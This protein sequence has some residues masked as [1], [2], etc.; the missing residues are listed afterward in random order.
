MKNSR[1]GP[2][3]SPAT[4]GGVADARDESRPGG[5]F[6]IVGIG[7]SAGGLEAFSAL[8]KHL[9]LDTGMGF[10]LVQHLDP[11]H[12]SALTQLLG[13]ASLLPVHEVTNNLRVEPNHV[14]VIPPNTNLGITAGVLTLRPR[15]RTRTPHRSIDF[16]LEAL[17]KDQR[18]H[19]IGV[20]LSGTATDGTL[21]LEAIKAEG[22]ITFAQDDSARYDSMPRSAVAAGAVDFILSPEDVARELARIAKHPAVAGGFPGGPASAGDDRASATANEDDRGPQEAIAPRTEDGF[23]KILLLLRNHSS[24]DFSLYKSSTIQRRITRRMVLTKHDTRERYAQFLRGNSKELGAL[25]SDVLISVTSFFRNP[26]AFEVLRRKVWPALLQQRGDEPLRVWTVGCS[27]GQEAYSLAMSFVEA[28][29]KAPRM[30][31]LQLFATDLNDALLDKARQGLYAKNVAQDLSSERLRRFFV[32]EAS[33]YR[34]SK[35][36]REMVV[37]ARQNVVSDPPFSRMDLISCRN[38]LI[39]FEPGLQRK[40]FPA[41]HYALKPGA[42][43]YLGASESVGGFTELFDPLDKKHRIYARKAAPTPAFPLQA[44]KGPGEPSHL[45]RPIREPRQRQADQGEVAEGFRGELSARREADRVSANRFAPPAVL[46]NADLQILQF[47]GPTGAYLE[48]PTG[49]PSFDVLKM[50]RPG[51]ML[52]LRSAINKAKK[53]NTR[54]RREHVRLEGAGKARMVNVE[55]IPLR[56]LRERCFLVV[57]EDADKAGPAPAASRGTPRLVEPPP[58]RADRAPRA[59]ESRR[60]TLLEAELAETRGYVQSIQEPHAAANEELQAS[61]QEVQSANEELQSIN[62]ELETFKE[63]LE[64]A[65]EELTTLNDE[66]ADRHTEL[67]RLHSDLVN[68]QTSAHL[69]IVLLGRDLTI[70]RFSAHAAKQLNLLASDVGRPLSHVRHTLEVSDLEPFVTEVID[71]VRAREREVQ[72]R[73]GRWLSL[74]VRPYLTLDNK[75]DGAVLVLVD[76]DDLKR[77][78]LAL[79]AAR[80]YA[81]S[82]IGTIRDPLVVL[83][84]DLRVESV[85]RAFYRTFGVTPADTIGKFIYELGNRQW[86]I[87][88]FRAL[89]EE[90]LPE[91]HTI[92]DFL[93]EWD[94]EPRGRRTMLLNAR[95]MHSP[96]GIPSRIVVAIDDIT[97]RKQTEEKL[98]GSEQRF[99]RF[100]EHLPGL[101]WI[102]DAHGRYVYANDAAEKAFRR[103]RTQLY[104]KSDRDLFPQETAARFAAND[105]QVQDTESSIQAIE[106]LEHEDGIVHQSIVSKFSIPGSDGEAGLVG[107]VAIDIT[108]LKEA[109][110]AL[111]KSEERYRTLFASIDEGFCVIERVEGPPSAPLDFRYVE[112]NPAFAAHTGV[113]GVVG[114][115]IRQAFPGEPEAW[116]HTYDHVL[117]TG[118]AMRFECGLVTQGRVLELYA[119]RIEDDSHRRVAVIFKDVTAR[120]RAEEAQARLAAI[121]ASSDDA[122]VSKDLDGVITSWNRG[123]ERLFGYSAQE[124]IGQPI[125]LLIPPDRLD[126]ERGIVERI[127]RGEGVDHFETIRRRRDGT[128]FDASVTV[129]PIRDSGGT[130]V[131]ASKIA[132]DIT[133]RNRAEAAVRD[134]EE[135][136]RNLFDLGPVAVYSCDAAGVIQTFNRRA[137]ELWGREPVPGDTDQRFCGSFKMFRPDGRFMPHEQCPMAEVLAGIISEARDAEV[138]IERPDGTRVI[139]VVNIR[140]LKNQHGEITGAI[141]CFYDITERKQ[142][143]EAMRESDR[144]KSEFL[145]MLAHELRNPLAPILGSIEVLSRARSVE[146]PHPPS[147]QGR[148]DESGATTPD[149][150][151]RIDHA[152]DV[153]QRQVGHM[154]R[155]VDDLLDAG[156]ISR[157]KID[158][159]RERVE[160]SSVLHHVV[161]AVRPSSE[162][163]DQELTVTLPSVPVYLDADSTRLAQIVG[164]LLNNA[165]KFTERGGHIWLTAERGE[166]SGA[167]HAE[168]ASARSAPHVVIRVRDTGI[169]IAAEPLEHVFDMF[170]QGD[171][172]LER[173]L[174]GLGIGLTLVKTLTEMH[175]GTVE[176]RSGGVGQG[177]E[178][179]VRLPIAVET[180]TP[181]SPP[182]ATESVAPT[183]LRILIVDDNR[184]SADMLDLLLKRAGHETHTAHDGLAA[185]EAA[186]SLDPDVILLDIGL[187]VLN[188]YEAARRIREQQ[189]QK[190]RPLLVALT[191]WGQDEDRRRSREAGFDAHVVKPVNDTVLNR[192]LAELDAG[193]QEVRD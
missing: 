190:R 124:A 35:A 90:I 120:R 67:N 76:I 143:E 14:Y 44:R 114:K 42:F 24:V 46:I 171:T 39:Y 106:T 95:R 191:G 33:G 83:D 1:A 166:E 135:R 131:G 187:P 130:V 19:A 112:A 150:S 71:S 38:L 109:E 21:G 158:L 93:L 13:R 6:P 77:S 134:S 99:A 11:E 126:E 34:V 79:A 189:S 119:F 111:L 140:P 122:I 179:V 94:F 54:A 84:P 29:D 2:A 152:L 162:S 63:E 155:L 74:R 8:L 56:N 105:R 58:A 192:L 60:N 31:K 91:S 25:Y 147:R 30:R 101:A 85:N 18:E 12:E 138:L 151:D 37:F 45:S 142:A 5:S 82:I 118:E 165:S 133:E 23:K 117:R 137:A 159:R 185:V 55:V 173:S 97:E 68:I 59:A 89:L 144:R 169:G 48:P 28:A 186:T 96:G 87:P 177:S 20:I 49:K 80:E 78:E 104:G 41:F 88:E 154:V 75:V 168:G 72:D 73:D 170:A 103:P 108:E 160:L 40:V 15:P 50:A 161:D 145:A 32:E 22:G 136:Y 53:Q 16:F 115:T 180:A 26:D 116:F 146:G 172:S 178:F 175:G 102:K 156:R 127:R 52:P 149:P 113:S 184:D 4:T 10:V 188:G 132:R 57:F 182:R 43:L 107:G 110:E 153:L 66:M 163:R 123:A 98:R 193:R 36:L 62:E 157:G 100:M 128:L 70:R 174:T 181:A 65:N 148:A 7:A 183:P 81:E 51:L 61:N 3:V 125:T 176:A 64:S 121:V 47:R 17:A 9:P 167:D 139:V 129:S 27:T 86:D 92:E 69:A 141:N 164:N